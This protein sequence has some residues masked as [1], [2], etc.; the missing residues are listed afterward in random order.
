M[1]FLYITMVIVILLLIEIIIK[2]G[3]IAKHFE[4]EEKMSNEEIEKE[5]NKN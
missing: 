3:K 2:L 1:L 5:L 4:R